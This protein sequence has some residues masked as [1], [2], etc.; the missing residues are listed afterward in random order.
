[1][2]TGGGSGME[3]RKAPLLPPEKLLGLVYY[4][5]RAPGSNNGTSFRKTRG[6]RADVC[7]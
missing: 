7:F 6:A 2:T 1:M 4:A 3:E 5:T